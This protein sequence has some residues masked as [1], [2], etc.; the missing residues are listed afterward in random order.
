MSVLIPLKS[1]TREIELKILKDLTCNKDTGKKFG[2]TVYRPSE[3][4][5]IKC[6]V[7]NAPYIAIPYYY[8]LMNFSKLIVH[9]P[10]QES[11]LSFVGQLREDQTLHVTNALADL[12]RCCTTTLAFDTSKGK[13]ISSIYMSCQLSGIRMVMFNRE[14]LLGQWAETI[15]KKTAKPN[16]NP[17]NV[18]VVTDGEYKPPQNCYIVI[19]NKK[20]FSHVGYYYLH[21]YEQ[22]KAALPEDMLMALMNPPDFVVCLTSRI[23]KLPKA[24][25]DLVSIL[26]LDEIHMLANET[27]KNAMLKVAPRYV[28]GCSATPDATNGYNA[29]ITNILGTHR[30]ILR[31]E[32]QVTVYQLETGIMFPETPNK[33]GTIDF[34]ALMKEV[35]NCQA[36]NT[37]IVKLVLE[38][39]D[40][41]FFVM[42][43]RRDHATMLVAM[44]KQAGVNVG[45]LMG[46]VKDYANCRV[47]IITVK[48][49]G[50]GF[51]E[52]TF[53]SDFDGIVTDMLIIA[54]SF[55]DVNMIKQSCGRLRGDTGTIFHLVDRN[56]V[57]RSQ[58]YEFNKFYKD[59]KFTVQKI[60]G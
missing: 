39:P 54:T 57:L 1:L 40:K 48:K 17:T 15:S 5:A 2:M 18:W 36:R 22:V 4:E 23:D 49:G 46:G 50:V 24:V 28:I 9:L 7:P 35:S 16:G 20:D 43:S 51:D 34:T 38:Y 47:L 12:Q 27:G 59:Y 19:L 44:M 6:W 55:R 41:K 37:Y 10:K 45:L 14:T 25:L 53:C 13:T 30:H 60:E 3:A 21:Q 31:N 29:I 42:V 26:I 33:Q 8:G 56:K 32:K 11:K 52:S 58:F